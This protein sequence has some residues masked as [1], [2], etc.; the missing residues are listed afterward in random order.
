MNELSYNFK[1]LSDASNFLIVNE[2]IFS[3][4]EKKYLLNVASFIHLLFTSNRSS[5][6]G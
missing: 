6:R 3:R 1:P 5:I 4:D 2:V